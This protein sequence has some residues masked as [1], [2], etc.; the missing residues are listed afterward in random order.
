MLSFLLQLLLG[1]WRYL[2]KHLQQ[3][4]DAL[5]KATVEYLQNVQNTFPIHL[6]NRV[7]PKCGSKV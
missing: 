6:L 1:L 3:M 2:H 4:N 5:V 7:F